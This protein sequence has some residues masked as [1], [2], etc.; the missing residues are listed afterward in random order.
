[1]GVGQGRLDK[2]PGA[3]CCKKLGTKHRFLGTGAHTELMLKVSA[4][5][6]LQD[7]QEALSL[8]AHLHRA[9]VCG[10][11]DDAQLLMPPALLAPT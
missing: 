1:M 10:E 2:C 11:C 7:T 4:V 8:Q 3:T 9:A 5:G 6:T